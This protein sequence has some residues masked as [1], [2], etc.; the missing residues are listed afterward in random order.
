MPS[1][2]AAGA[3]DPSSETS[4]DLDQGVADPGVDDAAATADG[5]GD[6]LEVDAGDQLPHDAHADTTTADVNEAYQDMVNM[7]HFDAG[8]HASYDALDMDV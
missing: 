7:Q 4:F 5:P 2:A 6:G 1:D 3:H 8:M